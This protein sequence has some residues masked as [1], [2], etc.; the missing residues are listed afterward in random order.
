MKYKF[1]KKEKN[2]VEIELS[3]NEQE[4]ANYLEKAYEENKGKYKVEGFRPGKA[5]K[6]VIEA[7]YGEHV[8]IEPALNGAFQAGY[9]EVLEKEKDF[10]PISDPKIDI[11]DL[12]EDKLV[13]KVEVEVMP[14]VKLGAYTG[15]EIKKEKRVASPEDVEHELHH[16]QEH[17]GRIVEVEHELQNGNIANMDFVGAIDGVKFEGGSA[18]NYDLE[19]GSGTFIPGFEDQ[20]VGMKKDEVKDIKVTFPAD[21]GAKDLAGKEAVFTVT[22][23]AVKEKQ[24][25][26]LD[27]EFAKDVSEFDTLEEYKKHIEEHINEH[28]AEHAEQDAENKLIDEI[29]KNTEVEIPE[30]LINQQLDAIMKDLEYR[31]MYQGLTLQNYAEYLNKTVEQIREENK[32]NAERM[33]KTRLTLEAIIKAENLFI[34]DEEVDA[35]LTEM[36]KAEHKE[37]EEFKKTVNQNR[38]NYVKNDILMSKL[39]AM[40]KEKNKISE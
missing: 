7:Q 40:L 11:K 32:E 10:D 36:A 27:D 24:L 33:V 5:P 22:V 6:S 35:K 3:F 37:L 16:A 39:I 19:I 12:K 25:P 20:M 1:T 23:H 29:A 38:L 31:L 4:W 17:A 30:T 15:L 34:T 8:F 9:M 18:T 13:L 2:N 26:A 21:Y 28:L 14:E